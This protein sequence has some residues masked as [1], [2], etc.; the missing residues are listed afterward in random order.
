MSIFFTTFSKIF[1]F[2]TALSV[3]FIL[4]ILII[5]FLDLSNEK[6]SF[7]Y[8]EGN[9]KS[10]NKIAL[11]HLNGPIITEPSNF[12]NF[13]LLNQIDIIYPSLVKKYLNELSKEQIVGLIFTINSPGGS[14]SASEQI[15]SMI[16]DF[17]IKKNLKIYFH[18]SEMLASG[19]YWVALSGDK[20]FS[21]YGSLVGSIGVKG[22]DWLYYN[23][24][25]AL[26]SGFLG[27][28]V[29]SENGIQMFSNTAGKSK[30]ILNPFRTPSLKEKKQ[31][32]KMVNNIYED[33]VNLVS[34]NRKIEKKI[35]VNEIGAMIYDSKEA[36]KNYLINNINNLD[37]VLQNMIDD[38]FLEDYQ[39]IK[40]NTQN[41]FS[42][43]NM[44][45]YNI[46]NNKD[47]FKKSIDYV[48]NKICYNS[49]HELSSIIYNSYN[50]DC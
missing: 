45:L 20:I 21:S 49:K 17:K 29:E 2:L 27:T 47:S 43:K 50:F 23:N 10:L 46:I 22:P 28:S 33:F 32:Q 35:I 37:E 41:V 44:G 6:D 31:L 42:V 11:V 7:Q 3:F 14:V 15:Y 34:K 25:N 18:S 9:E 40:K 26:S 13:G 8:L 38:L 36:K 5:N 30:D 1:G 19:G 4:I 48:N 12:L 24:P 16:N 39:V